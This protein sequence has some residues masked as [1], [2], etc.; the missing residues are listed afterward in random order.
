M[1]DAEKYKAALEKIRTLGRAGEINTTL[2][3]IAL[4]IIDEALKEVEG[5]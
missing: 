2:W 5:K 1:T 3:R 4:T